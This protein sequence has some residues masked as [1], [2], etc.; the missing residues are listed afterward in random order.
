MQKREFAKGRGLNRKEK[1]LAAL[2][3]AAKGGSE[4]SGK[5]YTMSREE[6]AALLSGDLKRVENEFGLDQ[7]D[8]RLL[9]ELSQNRTDKAAIRETHMTGDKASVGWANPGVLGL[10]AF[11]FTTLLLQ[12]HNIGWISSTMP[13]IWGF[14]WGGAA[15]VIAGVIDARRGDTLGFTAF[16]S[17][18]SFWIGLAFAFLL[19]WLGIITLD[20][21]GLAWTMIAWGLSPERFLPT[22]G[23]C[24]RMSR[25]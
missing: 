16:T 19:E 5:H 17:Y 6:V 7:E 4:T 1:I 14:F 11:G 12:I 21:P 23:S 18:G 15:Q 13:V 20:G 2:I 25:P 9:H 24:L 8:A 10:A 3:R 22:V